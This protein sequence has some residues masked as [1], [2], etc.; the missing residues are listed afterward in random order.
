MFNWISKRP[1]KEEKT[2]QIHPIH[3]EGSFSCAE[4]QAL[5]PLL[6]HV[7]QRCWRKIHSLQIQLA[8]TPAKRSGENTKKTA[9]MKRIQKHQKEWQDHM[10]RLGACPVKLYK[11]KFF[12]NEGAYYWEYPNKEIL[13]EK[14]R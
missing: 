7:S 14:K 3:F 10:R 13:W 5:V 4:V 9:L 2:V 12:A 8:H 11:V 6:N 1:D